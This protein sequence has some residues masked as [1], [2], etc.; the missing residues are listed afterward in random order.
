MTEHL[1]ETEPRAALLARNSAAGIHH[2]DELSLPAFAEI[3][4]AMGEWVFEDLVAIFLKAVWRC[5]YEED[6]DAHDWDT[7]L[8]GLNIEEEESEARLDASEKPES[9]DID[10]DELDS[11]EEARQYSNIVGELENDTDVFNARET[12]F[13]LVALA[14]DRD[15]RLLGERYCT[16]LSSIR[17]TCLSSLDCDNLGAELLKICEHVVSLGNRLPGIPQL[18][19][20]RTLIRRA[21]SISE[22]LLDP[23]IALVPAL[24]FALLP[25]WPVSAGSRLRGLLFNATGSKP[26]SVSD[27]A[28]RLS[29]AGVTVRMGYLEWWMQNDERLVT[30]RKDHKLYVVRVQEMFPDF[31]NASHGISR[32][33]YCSIDL[34]KLRY[35][36]IAWLPAIRLNQ[37]IELR[38]DIVTK[39]FASRQ[40]VFE[41]FS[42]DWNE[43]AGKMLCESFHQESLTQGLRASLHAGIVSTLL[44]SGRAMSREELCAALGF[45]FALDPVQLPPGRL[46]AYSRH[47][48]FLDADSAFYVLKD[49]VATETNQRALIAQDRIATPLREKDFAF[50]KVLF[51][52]MLDND[53]VYMAYRLIA[54][55]GIAK[56]I[57]RTLSDLPVEPYYINEIKKKCEGYLESWAQSVGTDFYVPQSAFIERPPEM[58]FHDWRKQLLESLLERVVDVR[59]YIESI[60]DSYVRE[61]LA[62][63]GGFRL[64]S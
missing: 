50:S 61:H 32:E 36:P 23:S 55:D 5:V 63:F 12:V 8:A 56:R 42:V 19:L 10:E 44:K 62:R 37:D 27:I 21:I 47:K 38:T 25:F 59:G 20:D 46:L 17:D 26:L 3:D 57:A 4:S 64:A 60:E 51:L 40:R 24:Y 30:L 11:A 48:R 49:W 9:D 33:S 14:L 41:G 39:H 45:E 7:F 6:L 34:G 22:G 15:P 2:A 43:V 53:P 16:G 29:S 18:R 31:V 13:K 28:V 35:R 54:V 52:E 58:A 1:G